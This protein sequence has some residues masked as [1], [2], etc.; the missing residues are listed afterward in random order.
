MDACDLGTVR[1]NRTTTLIYAVFFRSWAV[2]LV[3]QKALAKFD[4]RFGFGREYL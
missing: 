2:G 1:G 3:G 4:E